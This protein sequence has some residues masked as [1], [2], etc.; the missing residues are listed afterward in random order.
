MADA[1]GGGFLAAYRL[2]GRVAAPV[3]PLFVRRRA[4]RGKEDGARIAERYGI[5]SRPRPAGPLVWVHAASVGELMS[6]L[7]LIER[8][9]ARDV[10][11]LVTTGT[12]TSSEVAAQ[13]LP[14]GSFHQFAPLDVPR[15]VRR[16]LD[17]WK[18][19]LALFV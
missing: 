19:N 14:A 16:F 11:V 2:A 5:A 12:V 1:G 8:I 15:Y 10:H 3:I 9:A 18:P 17:H 7:P 6:V 13:R 4:A